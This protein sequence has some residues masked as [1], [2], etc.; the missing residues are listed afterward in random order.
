MRWMVRQANRHRKLV[1]LSLSPLSRLPLSAAQILQNAKK[2]EVAVVLF[3]T[4]DT[5]NALATAT[6]GGYKHVSVISDFATVSEV[7][8]RT[9]VWCMW[10]I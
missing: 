6:D 7:G 3:G 1:T 4:R 5:H 10:D 9:C 2:A 8:G